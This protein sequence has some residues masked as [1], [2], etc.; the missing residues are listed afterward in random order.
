ME[1]DQEGNHVVLRGND[2]PADSNN[3]NNSVNGKNKYLYKLYE[4]DEHNKYIQIF[5]S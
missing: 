4:C 5:L 2:L 1:V 3:N